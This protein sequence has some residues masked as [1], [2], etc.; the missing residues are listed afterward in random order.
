VAIVSPSSPSVTIRDMSP[1]SPSWVT[2]SKGSYSNEVLVGWNYV[3]ALFSASYKVWR[4]T[5]TNAQNA[6]L[7]ATTTASTYFDTTATPD[8]SYHYWVQ[9]VN[10]AGVSAF[11]VP[12]SGYCGTIANLTSPTGVQASKGNTDR[13]TVAW[14]AVSK[15]AYYEVWRNTGNDLSGASLVGRP[16][17]TSYDD[18][19]VSQGACYYYWVKAR[20]AQRDGDFSGSVAGWRLLSAPGGMRASDGTY[21]Y[22]IQVA[23]NAVEGA[24]SYDVWRKDIPGG[25]NGVNLIQ[26]AQTGGLAFNDYQAKSGAY[27]GYEVKARNALCSSLD[28]GQSTGRRQVNATPT[29]LSAMNDYDGDKMSDL[30]LFNPSSGV[31]DILCSKLG[32]QTVALGV[33]RNQGVT[34]DYDGDRVADPVAYSPDSGAWLIRLSSMN[35]NPIIRGSFGGNGANPVAADFDGDGLTDIG[36]YDEGKGVLSIIFSH[37][38]AFDVRAS[39]A[40]GG[41]GYGFVSADFDGDKLADPTAYSESEGRVTILF[42]GIGYFPVNVALGGQGKAMYAADFDGDKLAD[43]VLYEEATGTW[44]VSL[45]SAG[46]RAARISFGGPGYVPVIADYDG[47]G[48]ADP[49]VYRETDGQWLI[50]FSTSNYSV[51]TETFGGSGYQSMAK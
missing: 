3:P 31:L 28:Y 18:Y 26:V 9:A 51:I 47:D 7:L 6:A 19:S 23:W 1:P 49:A 30:A 8:V 4:G 24:I 40:M 2:A 38:G 33:G 14:Q 29:S 41:P 25:S 50:M 36:T 27:Y 35:Y 10:T 48:L 32:Q 5:D 13:I 20:T 45:S 22:H 43:P 21:P 42:S 34:G 17:G 37:K 15:A 46:Y 39:G 44:A 16:A 12:D 11:S